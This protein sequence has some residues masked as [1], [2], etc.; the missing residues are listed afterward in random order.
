MGKRPVSFRRA[1]FRMDDGRYTYTIMPDYGCAPYGWAAGGNM[2]DQYGWDGIH[3][4][5][6]ELEADFTNW[7]LDFEINVR[8][9]IFSGD[10]RFDWRNFHDRGRA[11][12]RRLKAELGPEI[13][14]I[15]KKPMEDPEHTVEESTEILTDGSLKTLI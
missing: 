10:R 8:P 3:P 15:Y 6:K 5:S 14:V 7:A 11:L 1:R 9:G 13:R 4:I 12:V 2:A